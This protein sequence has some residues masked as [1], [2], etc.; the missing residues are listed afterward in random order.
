MS[1][2]NAVTAV[3][4]DHFTLVRRLPA[5]TRF[6]TS[7]RASGDQG[8]GRVHVTAV[9]NAFKTLNEA[10]QRHK[11]LHRRIKSGRRGKFRVQ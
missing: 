11:E 4:P 5:A 3:P 8:Q 9:T 7:P 10:Q 2:K 1:Q 6:C